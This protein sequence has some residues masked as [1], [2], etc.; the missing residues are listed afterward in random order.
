MNSSRRKFIKNL[1]LSIPVVTVPFTGM[2]QNWRVNSPDL[3]AKNKF[4][5]NFKAIKDRVWIGPEFWAVPME[6]WQIKSGRL[7]FSGS[8]KAARL[9]LLTYLLGEQNEGFSISTQM[10]LLASKN[11]KGSAGF[12]V[13]IKDVT[14][15]D[16]AKAACY[17]GQGLSI[18]VSLEGV[19]FL[20][21]QK[22][23]LPEGF[24]F[25]SFSLTAHSKSG[26]DLVVSVKDNHS[27]K[28]QITG[29]NIENLSGLFALENNISSANES[30]F[31]W[32]NLSVSGDKVVVKPENSFGPILWTMYTLSNQKLKLSAQLP[33]V[34]IADSK[35]VQLEV[36]RNNSWQKI[37]Q[38]T[39]DPNSYVGTFVVENWNSR[40]DIPYRVVYQLDKQNHSYEGTIRKEPAK[41]KLVFGGL[42]CQH[43]LGFPY[44]PLVQ[45]LEKTNPDM[46]YFSG[47]QIYEE[48]GGYPIK[49][50]PEDKAI[51]S[52]LGKIYMFGWAFGNIMRDR[53]TI[54]TPDDHDVFQG[55]LWGEGGEKISFE[56]WE[57]VRDAHGGFVQ[58][59]SMI[60][61]VNST[62]CA[63]LPDPIDVNAMKSGIKAWHTALNY[64]GVSFAIVSDRYF[65]SGPEKIIQGEGRIDHIIEP[66]PVGE[67]ESKDL[68]YLGQQQM[69]FLKNWV[70]D[71]HNA[72]MKVLLSQ[73]LFASVGT[74]HGPKKEYLTGDL[75]SGG[76]PKKQKDE[77]LKLLR[78]AYAFH[79]NGDQHLPFLVKYSISE[80]QDGSWTFC[81]PAIAAGYPRWGQPDSV[82][83]PFTQRPQ[84]NLP[85]TGCYKDVFGNDN[86][87]YAV[88]NPEDDFNV[89]NDRYLTA[90]KKASGFGLITF[91]TN[92]RT[93]K[94]EA[95]RFLADLDKPSPEN[96]YPGWP[97]TI[98]QFDNDGRR[99]IGF[100]PKIVS[101]IPNQVLTVIKEDTD[102]IIKSVRISGK[103]Y[104]PKI[105]EYGSY[106]IEIGEGTEKKKLKNVLLTTDPLNTI[107]V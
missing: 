68:H 6:D 80:P 51:L 47:D 69:D 2:A 94:M 23:P 99:A 36:K 67:L 107:T 22:I 55:N 74:H 100:L 85:N 39:I 96:H 62:Q 58:A 66:I 98:S 43:W 97:F 93:I 77:V 7:E 76:W 105:Y 32:Q 20:G 65:K 88:G 75:D 78:K 16:S 48:N 28:A 63:H 103:E 101:T 84:H 27:K 4:D 104:Q 81:T 70:T 46:L 86:F 102:E 44:R 18:G 92:E 49:R 14:D 31:W 53:P 64:G 89:K 8:K 42:T 1:G 13:G 95:I 57:K 25:E 87:V 106:T 45:N 3:L 90:Q 19:L 9:H 54:C 33:P 72:D 37:S 40:E 12:T 15:P 50:Q 10:G 29:T 71:W 30:T 38:E 61:V 91:D 41:K 52:Y 73:T 34:G 5:I 59:T 56:G 11:K 83:V 24:N 17:Y 60:N 79:I 35:T 26:N 82:N 21:D